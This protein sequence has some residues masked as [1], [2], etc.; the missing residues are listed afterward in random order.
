MTQTKYLGCIFF[1]L[2]LVTGMVGAEQEATKTEATVVA[3]G[4]S[5][6]IEKQASA[7]TEVA[8]EQLATGSVARSTFST[9]IQNRE[10]VDQISSL[11]NDNNIVYFFTELKDL[12]G[13]QAMHRWEYNGEV[14]AEVSFHVGGDRWRVW[15]SKNLQP[16]LTGN[17]K[18]SVI[19]GSGDVIAIQSLQYQ[20]APEQPAVAETESAI[21][22][23]ITPIADTAAD[24]QADE[25]APIEGQ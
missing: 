25:S 21:D 3:E 20:A 17:W 5:A 11:T 15:S 19:N 1:S 13:Q 7:G 16:E 18:V 9:D 23:A 14:I 6:A 2:L 22:E 4:Q 10:P 8:S 12:K 24:L